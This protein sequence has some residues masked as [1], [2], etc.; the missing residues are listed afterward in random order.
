MTIQ[1]SD[2]ERIARM[3]ESSYG[4][5]ISE[6]FGES[7]GYPFVKFHLDL[8]PSLKSCS[9]VTQIFWKSIEISLIPDD[10]AR[11]L[12]ESMGKSS[13]GNQAF[14]VVASDIVKKQGRIDFLINGHQANP[15]TPESWDSEWSRVNLKLTIFTDDVDHADIKKLEP[16]LTAWIGRFFMLILSLL[17]IEKEQISSDIRGMPEGALIRVMV[18]KYERDPVNREICISLNGCYCHSCGFDF[19]EEYGALGLGFVHV[20]HKTPVSQLGKDYIINPLE[21]LVPVCPNCHAMIH[22]TDPPLTIDQL[23]D[24]IK[25]RGRS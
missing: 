15:I 4:I 22:K 25:K 9:V 20:H 3:I 8:L 13:E 7:E 14:S 1:K 18:N 5:S 10:Y 16:I 17:P 24:L 23:K 11:D 12:V 6:T 2:A 19:E 21:D